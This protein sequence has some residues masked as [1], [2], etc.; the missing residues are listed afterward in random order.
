MLAKADKPGRRAIAK[1][2]RRQQLIDATIKC[3]SKKG[4]GSTTLA[5]VAKEA[6]LSQ[7]IVNLHFDSKDNLLAET[8]KFL[9]EE[10]DQQFMRTLADAPASPASRLLALMQMCLKPAVCD[11]RKLAVWFAFWGEVKAVP[12]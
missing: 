1:A 9:A 3:I 6:G 7:G 4:L 2:R 5:D 10:Y 11:R 12:T 8:L